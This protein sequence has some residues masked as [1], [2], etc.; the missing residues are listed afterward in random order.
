MSFINYDNSTGGYNDTY[1]VTYDDPI[2]NNYEYIENIDNNINSTSSCS[3]EN[4]NI[5][6]I[7]KIK[8]G[9]I[10]ILNN[11]D[12]IFEENINSSGVKNEN[13]KEINI[14][15]NNYEEFRKNYIKEQS[16]YFECEKNL[17]KEIEKSKND[18]KKLDL[19][20]KFI[21]E[22][23]VGDC[24]DGLTEN[25][26]ENMKKLSKQIEES[27]KISNLRNIYI[28]SRKI[29]NKYLSFL[30]KLN[31]MN[32]A[33]VCPLCLTNVVNVYLNPCG[34]TCCD[35]CYEK[36]ETNHDLHCFLCRNRIIQKNPLYFS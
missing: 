1:N 5:T 33:N 16:K 32:T 29:I 19:I 21:K 30:K 6:E 10:N 23:D 31:N 18:I 27:N 2:V 26:V 13:D 34:H 9:I 14:L 36:L 15:I 25:I 7:I 35:S 4:E 24:P 8:N 22:L 12:D 3:E 28:D 17:N 20:V 11:N